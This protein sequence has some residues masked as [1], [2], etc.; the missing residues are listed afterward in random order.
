MPIFEAFVLAAPE[1][2]GAEI[3]AEEAARLAAEEAARQLAIQAAEQEAARVAAQQAAEQASINAAENGI[4]QIAQN[5]TM[6]PAQQAYM[7][8]SNASAGPGITQG[9]VPLAPA[10]TPAAAPSLVNS[11]GSLLS[12]ASAPVSPYSL[13]SGVTGETLK[14]A[15]AEGIKASAIPAQTSVLGQPS[16]LATG[17]EKGA[18]GKWRYETADNIPFLKDIVRL[19]MDYMKEN[20]VEDN[21]YQ[22]AEYFL[23]PELMLLYPELNDVTIQFD[24][25]KGESEGQYNP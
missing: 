13:S 4:T 20:K 6:T 24:K 8:A 2:V 21:V 9:T 5:S 25:G 11:T 18:D 16:G 12:G 14:A 10:G 15:G 22:K 7:Q 3:A 19:V 23:P 1:V 17:W